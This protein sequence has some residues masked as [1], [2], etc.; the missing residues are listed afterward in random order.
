MTTALQLIEDSFDDIGIKPAET[1]L[2]DSEIAIGIRRLNRLAVG[3]ASSGLNFGFTKV[4]NK[5]EVLTIPDWSEDLFI[6]HLAIRL[7]PGFDVDITPGLVATA[8]ESLKVVQRRL[9][10]VPEV[11]FPTTLPIGSGNYDYHTRR[12][13]HDENENDLAGGNNQILSDDESVDLSTE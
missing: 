3:F 2:S 10:S 9:I 6:S 13:F 11:Q 5:D 4:T 7:A 1:D 8:S 12:F